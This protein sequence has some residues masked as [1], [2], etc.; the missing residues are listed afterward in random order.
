ML[1]PS[2][3]A[4]LWILVF[5]APA[6]VSLVSFRALFQLLLLEVLLL[7]LELVADLERHHIV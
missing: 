1:A 3:F 7:S 6:L 4:Q 2:R 5:M